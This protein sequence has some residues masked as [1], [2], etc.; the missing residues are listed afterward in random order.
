MK[1]LWLTSLML[2][3]GINSY[4]WQ[5]VDS[6]CPDPQQLI[7]HVRVSATRNK[8]QPFGIRWNMADSANYR[9][10]S[11]RP[12][13]VPSDDSLTDCVEATVGHV[14]N[15]EDVVEDVRTIY[16]RFDLSKPAYSLR[17]SLGSAGGVI[18]IGSTK[19]VEKLEINYD[20]PN[21][22]YLCSF[23][24]DDTELVRH[25]IRS[26]CR[27]LPEYAN[28]ADVDDLYKYLS[29][30]TDYHEGIWTYFDRNTNALRSRMGG[31]YTLATVKHGDY[32]DLIYIDGA[33]EC[34]ADWQPLRI[35]G[36]LLPVSILDTFLLEWISPDG[37]KI[38][39]ETGAMIE[40][41][42]LTFQ[43]P[44]WHATMRFSRG[45]LKNN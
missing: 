14:S 2:F 28:F 16:G 38:D 26:Q 19:I 45:I 8:T 20:R 27:E 7:Y 29:R 30:S 13:G 37:L 32:Y 44:Y 42:I 1:H 24:S 36:R 22:G 5:V 23:G 43:F 35:K 34:S 9:Y 40:N 21:N 31:K 3:A 12:L 15:G 33:D 10:L 41:D 25:D 6:V 39:F 18:E 4:A 11:L 17:L